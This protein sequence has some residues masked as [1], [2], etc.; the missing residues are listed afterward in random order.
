MEMEQFRSQHF[1]SVSALKTIDQPF[2]EEMKY[3]ESLA[4]L[5]KLRDIDE[6]SKNRP[7][8]S[9]FKKGTAD[10]IKRKIQTILGKSEYETGQH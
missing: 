4:T 9:I 7:S 10:F 1:K 6:E 3:S 5:T 8:S 2:S